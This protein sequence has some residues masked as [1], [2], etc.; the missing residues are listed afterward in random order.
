MA[1]VGPTN[2][3]LVGATYQVARVNNTILVQAT[4]QVARRLSRYPRG[5]P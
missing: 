5:E 4:Y 1:I 3:I 2:T